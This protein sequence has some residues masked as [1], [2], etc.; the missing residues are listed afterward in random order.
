MSL[1]QH[2][3]KSSELITQPEEIRSGFIALALEKN[4]QATLFLC[5]LLIKRGP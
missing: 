5:L 2:L 3:S 1:I 4:R